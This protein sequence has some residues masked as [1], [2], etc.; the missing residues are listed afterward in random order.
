MSTSI[1]ADAAATFGGP[2]QLRQFITFARRAPAQGLTLDDVEEVCDTLSCWP[3][4]TT[5]GAPV[6]PAAARAARI[7]GELIEQECREGARDVLRG[8]APAL[9]AEANNDPIAAARLAMERHHRIADPADVAEEFGLIWADGFLEV[10]QRAAAGDA[11]CAAIVS[12]EEA[13]LRVELAG[14]TRLVAQRAAPDIL[15][16][17][18]DGDNFADALLTVHPLVTPEIAADVARSTI[19]RLAKPPVR[20]Y[21]PDPIDP[22]ASCWEE[23][24]EASLALHEKAMAMFETMGD[25]ADVDELDAGPVDALN[26]ALAAVR[27]GLGAL[28]TSALK[29]G[30]PEIFREA[31]AAVNAV[32]SAVRRSNGEDVGGKPAHATAISAAALMEMEFDNIKWVVPGYL[33]EGLT[34]LAGAPKIG[35]SWL[36]L[37]IALAVASGGRAFEEVE[38][39]AGAVLYLALEDNLRRLQSRLRLMGVTKGPAGLH[40][41][42]TWPSIDE[43][44]VA[45]MSGWLDDNP[46]ARMIVIDVLAKIK[47]AKGGNK[48]QYDAD[49]KD[50][51]ALQRLALDRGIAIVLVHHTRKAEA[52]GDPFDLVSGTRGL[53]GSADSTFVL[54][55]ASGQVQPS[56]Y[57]RGRDITEIEQAMTFDPSTCRWSIAGPV[58]ELQASAERQGIIDVLKRSDAPMQ[59]ADIA[60]AVQRSAKSVNNMLGKMV[61]AG[62]VRKVATGQYELAPPPARPWTPAAH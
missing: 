33:T 10:V 51:T 40:F 36:A 37:G 23:P 57:G 32:D 31:L 54:T 59:L 22:W 56:L 41:E 46:D 39:E 6:R 11:T 49:Y 38:C 29:A 14:H 43:G 25:E 52:D 13:A 53:T 9:L 27:N 42:T 8:A 61:T 24:S 48:A 12:A 18:P 7:V 47:S 60:E 17:L 44:C 19:R 34:L 35:K 26:G 55:R 62:S 16:G 5:P 21:L 15:R 4:P 50:V 58:V 1:H 28:E 30:R 45:R 20:Q 2:H 3:A